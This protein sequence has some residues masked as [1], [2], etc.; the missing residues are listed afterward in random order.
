MNYIK[1]TEANDINIIKDKFENLSTESKLKTLIECLKINFDFDNKK[2]IKKL[3]LKDYK[4][5]KSI[6]DKNNFDIND[7]FLN[8]IKS[9]SSHIISY[10]YLTYSE[11]HTSGYAYNEDYRNMIDERLKIINEITVA[12]KQDIEIINKIANT[13]EINYLTSYNL[14]IGEIIID[15]Y[16]YYDFQYSFNYFYSDDDYSLF[17]AVKTILNNKSFDWNSF[18]FLQKKYTIDYKSFIELFIKKSLLYCTLCP[19]KWETRHIYNQYNDYKINDKYEELNIFVKQNYNISIDII[20]KIIKKKYDSEDIQYY[21]LNYLINNKD[22]NIKVG[23]C[24]INTK[25]VFFKDFDKDNKV[26]DLSDEEYDKLFNQDNNVI[27][28]YE[29]FE[30]FYNDDDRID[31]D[32]QWQFNMIKDRYKLVNEIKFIVN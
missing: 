8:I 27:Y 23:K 20:D 32:I 10:K 26:D 1:K 12:V 11:S 31:V 6:D 17:K 13:K 24:I 21:G 14:T 2:T 7:K 5:F 29:H 9:Y 18:K 28:L 15:C 22:E 16:L 3:L 30:S 19:D 25:P 4:I